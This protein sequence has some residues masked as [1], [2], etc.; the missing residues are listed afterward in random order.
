MLTKLSKTPTFIVIKN[1]KIKKNKQT[2]ISI[3]LL[4]CFADNFKS[5][6]I[7]FSYFEV[8]VERKLHDFKSSEIAKNLEPHPSRFQAQGFFN[9]LF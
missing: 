2:K 6:F 4:L 3:P 5:I 1:E 7:T 9:R 8:C